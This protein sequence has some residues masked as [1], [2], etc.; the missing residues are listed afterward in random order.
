MGLTASCRVA[1]VVVAIVAQR[2]VDDAPF[3]EVAQVF[4]LAVQG[5]TVL[6]AQHD[7]LLAQVLV[8][9]E[10]IRG[11]GNADILAVLGDDVLY[12]V[13]D[14]VGVF[15]GGWV[16]GV[17]PDGEPSGVV[18]KLLGEVGHHD[19]GV[20][21]SLGHFV[22]VDEDAWVAVVE[23]DVL[24]E[25]HRRVAVGVE[26]QRAAVHVAGLAVGGGFADE[27]V[28]EG[29]ALFRKTFGMPLYADDALM[30][31]ALHG[32]D[33]AVLGVGDGTETGAG[34]VYRLMVEGVDM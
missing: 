11:S 22:Q 6:D 29:R 23:L 12:L 31:C 28:E 4:Y 1:D 20:L 25:K 16:W 9:P 15:S 21:V 33:D 2:H 13:E 10:V 19:G 30:L 34:V 3:G 7:A 18:A 8:L 17:G 26:G 27:P 32:L 5:V 14:V 24:R